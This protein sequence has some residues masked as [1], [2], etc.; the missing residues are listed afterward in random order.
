MK[1][2][3]SRK[4]L[5][6]AG[7]SLIA[8][9]T[10]VFA[11]DAAAQ[12]AAPATFATAPGATPTIQ[13]EPAPAAQQGG[14]PGE[15]IVTANK[16]E[17]KLNDV[18]ITV[19]VVSGAQLQNRQINSLADIANSVPSLS[20]TNSA[21]GTPV[22][23]LRGIGFYETSLGAYPTVSTYVD[24]VPL[25]FPV[26]SSHS[27]YDLER[28]EVLKGPQGTL[29]GQ[30]ATGGAINY[31]AAKPKDTFGAGVDL[32][33]GRFNQVIGDAYITGPVTETIQYRVAGRVE[34]M[35]G[36][37]ESNTRPGDTNGKQRNYM[38]R[39]QVAFEPKDGMKFLLN[40]NGWKDGGQ[41]QAP[42]YE[43]LQPQQ[44][45]LDPLIAAAKFSPQT[46]RAADWT[47]GLPYKNN[48]LLQASLRSDIDLFSNVT[49][50]SIT[51]YVDYKQNQRDDGDGLPTKSLDLT[52]DRGRIKSFSQ[53]LRLSN[54]SHSSFRWVTGANFEHSTVDQE[55]QLEF[56]NASSNTTFGEFLGY[57]IS[58]ALYTTDQKFQNYAF[59]GNAEYDVIPTVTLKGGVRYT[60]AKDT[61]TICSVDT[62]GQPN[63]TGAFFYNVLHGGAFGPYAGQ[64]FP[65]NNLGTTVN[66]VAPGASGQY[67]GELHQHNISWK[68]GVDWKP[69]P[70]ILVY[71]NVAKGYKA[72]SFPTVSASVFS[73][74]L[75]VKQE[76]VQSYEG[77]FK[78][79][80][81]DRTLQFNAAGFYYDYSNKQ[82]RSKVDDPTF[83]ILDILQNIPKS[84][85]AGFEI[86]LD[87]T[88]TRGL[89][90]NTA[91]TYLKATIDK[92]TGINAAGLPGNFDG[93]PVPFTPKY[94]V[95]TNVDY[96]FAVSDRLD[97]FLGASLSYRSKT[98]SVVG[99]EFNPPTATPQ[100]LPIFMIKEYAL[101][102]LRAGIKSHDDKWRIQV[103]GK[104]ITN[105]Y[106]Y[107]N[108]VAATDTIGRYTGLP[109]TY[110]VSVGYKF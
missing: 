85:V 37:Q 11:Q 63:N 61:A 89:S 28:V 62:S 59:F 50:T 69:R 83:G 20:Y 6:S 39:L 90:I 25:A 33:Y 97:A 67:A 66:G 88:P 65:I 105:S 42:Q 70:G 55:V 68:A 101:L 81:I 93:T 45:V 87:A 41:T 15:I 64:C 9:P 7:I 27:A 12:T 91:F 34:R 21:N 77:G 14:T 16:R 107:T 40:A 103:Y 92:F 78:A 47:P 102:D 43:G 75:P 76:S 72:G 73:Q 32:T 110:G 36:W 99:G 51:A 79:T 56:P 8:C 5:L 106:Y 3:V 24:E 74:F 35:D 71:V 96:T 2:I 38:G 10:V 108:V 109:A 86:E 30:N 44:A 31:I 82:L 98:Y 1:M 46:D 13:P 54:G 49:L 52:S 26:L 58:N 17:Q 18:G 95:G 22:Y 48:R 4:A 53:E 19:S 57:P 84:T 29:F 23:T 100:G 60:N 104:N 80:L 94:Q